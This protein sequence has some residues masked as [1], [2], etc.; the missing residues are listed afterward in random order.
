MF[1]AT[2]KDCVSILLAALCSAILGVVAF[3]PSLSNG[4]V[5]DDGAIIVDRDLVTEPGP[6][7]RF[8]QEPWWPRTKSSDRLYRPLTLASFRMNVALAGLDRP[9]ARA[10]REVNIALHA[11]ACI[12]VV[13]AAWRLTHRSTAGWIAGALFAVHPVHTEAVVTGYGRAELLA[14]CLAAW[15][16][17]RYLWTPSPQRDR[18]VQFHVINAFLFLAA[19]MSKEHALFVWPVLVLIDLWRRRQRPVADRLGLRDWLN[20]IL[21]PSHVGFVF[22]AAVFLL[23]RFTV[24]GYRV[25]LDSSRTLV[26]ADPMGHA[27]F[28][29]HVLTPFR[30]GWLTLEVLVWPRWLCPIWSMSAL[31]PADHL[32]WDVAA[33]MMLAAVL[34]VIIVLCWRRDRLTG[35][36]LAGILV[37]L[38]IP[39]HVIPLAHWL[40]AE[41]WLYLPTVFIAVAVGAGLSRLRSVGLAVGLSTSFLL[42]P[43]VWQYGP[44]FADDHTLSCEVVRRQ[45]DNYMG[46]RNLTVQLYKAGEY[47]AAVRAANDIIERFN[48]NPTLQQRYEPI[49]M[50]YYILLK[51]YLALGDGFRAMDALKTYEWLRRDVPMPS[52][53]TA[54]R[55]Q[56]QALIDQQRDR[57][58]RPVSQTAPHTQ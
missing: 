44:T 33:G 3:V 39:L 35:A 22:A 24:F 47:A 42:L 20:R 1:F 4:F 28:V 50:P 48:E 8:W 53:L 6:W 13:L 19:L 31:M 32:T 58:E 7:Y 52:G 45:P 25:V 12:A 21:A 29:E 15:L 54:E 40:Y 14:G 17:A 11:L 5:Y 55:R 26:W 27:T 46:R 9:D 56:A 38:A 16:L 2:H 36:V 57:H 41:R 23:L 34:I 37:T 10:F 43:I 30:L 51:S 18:P 49:V